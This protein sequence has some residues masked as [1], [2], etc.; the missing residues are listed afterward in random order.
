MLG[1]VPAIVDKDGKELEGACQGYLVIK[2]P[3]PGQVC[4][5]TN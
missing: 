5:T 1:V 4:T 3:W 2:Y